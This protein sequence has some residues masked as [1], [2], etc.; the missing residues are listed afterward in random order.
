MARI[1]GLA[2]GAIAA[3]LVFLPSTSYAAVVNISVL[4]TG[5]THGHLKSF[6]YES[7]KP[8]GG[9]AK[10]A[11]YFQDR[12]RHKKMNWV[13]LDSGD[14]LSGTALSD[15]FQGYLDIEA[16][17]R[18]G[19]D[20]MGLGAHEFDYGV[21]V[22]KQ[23]MAEAKFPILSANVTYADSGKPL[24]K[25]Y[26]I[27]E[28]DGV[29][30]AIFGLTTGDLAH[31]VAPENFAGLA[32]SDPIDTARTLVPKL[33]TQADIVFA[34]THLGVNEDIRLAT[35]VPGIDLI[36][37][38]MSH[39][40]LQEGIQALDALIV[41]DG[42]YGRY[43]GQLKMSYSPIPGQGLVR[44]YY[45]N[46]L[47][48]IDGRFAENTNYVAWLGSF[49]PQF[50]E[51]MGTLVGTSAAR[52]DDKK[53]ASTEVELGDF[54]CDSLR[55]SLGA[56]AAILPAAF[57]CA[58][59]PEG[60]LTL[61]DL[62]T[63][64]PY[65]HSGVV[66]N[67]TGAELKQILDESADMLGRPGFPQVSGVSMG[68]FNGNAYQVRVGAQPLDPFVRYRLATSDALAD[69]ALGYAAMGTI[70]DRDYSGRLIRDI[71]RQRLATGLVASA[72]IQKRIQLL[73]SEP[74]EL[75]SVPPTEEEQPAE[76]ETGAPGAEAETAPAETAPAES[77]PAEEQPSG[78]ESTPAT[79]EGAGAETP[80]AES[81][82]GL[83]ALR[84]DRTGQPMEGQPAIHDEVIRD[85]GS[86]LT[87]EG[88]ASATPPPA[89]EEAAPAAPPVAP[90][91]GSLLSSAIEQA[92][93][94]AGGLDYTFYV[95]ES[96]R[97]YEFHLD[98]ANNGSAPVQCDFASQERF[99]FQ[100]F[101]GVD[102]LW[103]FNFNHFF[104]QSA[105]SET[106]DPG[107]AL[108]YSGDW[109]GLTNNDKPLPQTELHCVAVYA[110]ADAPVQL[111]F[112]VS[113]PR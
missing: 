1:L 7:A 78:V 102:L 67:V 90:P 36:V 56:D 60:V 16:M 30:I 84:Y 11:I 109:D 65:D 43:V 113:L 110:V 106:I 34:V 88:P 42:T 29:K 93:T 100:V 39:S 80:P 74:Q 71:V 97:G 55:E 51:K 32:V 21:A 24:T 94:T 44:H 31:R 89:P 23:R 59:L 10:R 9:V 14:A 52:M 17:N 83:D 18:L 66:L 86:D 111:G 103:T 105:G 48:L 27:I 22:L 79:P 4:Y 99:D 54:I 46:V 33:R 92:K 101:A 98:V 49:M 87:A 104:V 63:V 13:V 61:G 26:T 108:T 96:D 45:K 107:E 69:G 19:Y 47:E 2:I 58:P 5:D 53:V 81:A 25:P 3:V 75:A 37:G 91:G 50:Q 20:A 12:R 72:S 8:V 77:A 15:A 82:E 76:P 68:I 6:Y 112:D 35:Q 64:M 28:R 40:E 85:S 70:A 62:Y 38:G 41:H 73:G 95:V 57:F